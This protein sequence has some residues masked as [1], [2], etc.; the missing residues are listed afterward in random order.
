[1]LQVVVIIAWFSNSQISSTFFKGNVY[2]EAGKN[3]SITTLNGA[4][5]SIGVGGRL[6]VTGNSEVR[7]GFTIGSTA[8]GNSSYYTFPSTNGSNGQILSVSPTNSNQLE[9][10]NPSQGKWT[11]NGNDISNN[12]TGD[13]YIASS[14]T[15][16][17]LLYHGGGNHGRLGIAW[18]VQIT[19][20][21]Y[22]A[23]V[24]FQEM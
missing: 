10:T 9:W 19:H 13:V 6:T 15:S 8:P 11:T 12:N 3:V 14:S 21:M 20:Y 18:L 2:F 22:L 16:N 1:M 5:G 17:L 24:P 23:M 7:G 4:G